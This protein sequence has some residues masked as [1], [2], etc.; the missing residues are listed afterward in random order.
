VH[1]QIS[2]AA[3]E[4]AADEQSVQ[5]RYEVRHP[6]RE[7]SPATPEPG[8]PPAVRPHSEP[9]TNLARPLFSPEPSADMPVEAEAGNAHRSAMP[10]PTRST[11]Q[12]APAAKFPDPLVRQAI[13]DAIVEPAASQT[14]EVVV[15]ID[16]IDVHA[17][18]GTAPSPPEPRRVRAAPTS[19]ESYLRSRSRGGPR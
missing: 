4:E 15:H 1:S 14:S 5:V 8:S 13:V 19:L 11:R 17:H 2:P 7:A 6:R 10:E 18:T 3:I 9:L 16:R 12:P